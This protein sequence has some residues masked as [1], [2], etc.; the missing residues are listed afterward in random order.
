MYFQGYKNYIFL[1]SRHFATFIIQTIIRPWP[2]W[3]LNS[4]PYNIIYEPRGP[5]YADTPI[6]G[7]AGFFASDFVVESLCAR[8]LS[9]ETT[10]TTRNFHEQVSTALSSHNAGVTNH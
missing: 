6:S 4:R 10:P 1:N 2:S 9:L 3:N 8:L 5:S 7:S